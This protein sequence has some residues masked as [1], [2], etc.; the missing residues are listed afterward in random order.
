MLVYRITIEKY[1]GALF[2]SG[3][4][5][6]WNPK[7]VRMIY[8]AGS[9][10]LAC[11]ENVVHRNSLGLSAIFRTMVVEISDHLDIETIH[12]ADLPFGW[13]EFASYPVTQELGAQWIRSNHTAVLCVPSAIVPNDSNYLLNPAHPDFRQIVLSG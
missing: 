2:A 3:I 5:A 6:R 9:R 13:S 4:A 8:T 1:S 10:A 11:L 12:L 7:D